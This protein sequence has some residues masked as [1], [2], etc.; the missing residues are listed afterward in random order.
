VSDKPYRPCPRCR[1]CFTPG[2]VVCYPCAL[3]MLEFPE[4]CDRECTRTVYKGRAG[5]DRGAG[6]YANPVLHSMLCLVSKRVERTVMPPYPAPP[7]P[8]TDE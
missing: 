2:G 3:K 6:T 4:T 1:D 8:E 7:E 5:E